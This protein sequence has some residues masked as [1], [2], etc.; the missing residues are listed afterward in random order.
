MEVEGLGC[1]STR[2][3]A[4][5]F[6]IEVCF[7]PTPPFHP[8]PITPSRATIG[9]VDGRKGEEAKDWGGISDFFSVRCGDLFF[10]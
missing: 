1:V 8:L 10:F 7:P 4:R 2:V 9:N 3:Y 5:G 6:V